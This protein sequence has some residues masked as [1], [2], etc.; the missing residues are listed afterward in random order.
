M[1][2]CKVFF[3]LMLLD[4]HQSTFVWVNWMKISLNSTP[5]FQH[6]WIDTKSDHIQTIPKD[7]R[8]KYAH[9]FCVGRDEMI[10]ITHRP[11]H[12]IDHMT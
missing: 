1:S 12:A 9:A 3:E 4:S 2:T 10:H 8:G 5:I 6:M 7:G 11:Y